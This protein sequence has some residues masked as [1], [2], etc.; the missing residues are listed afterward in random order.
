MTTS[1][2]V[3]SVF[4]DPP[5]RRIREIRAAS[6]AKRWEGGYGTLGQY[7]LE[8]VHPL[9]GRRFLT[10]GRVD[11]M[12]RLQTIVLLLSGVVLA[13][14]AAGAADFETPANQNVTHALPAELDRG[15]RDAVPAPVGAASYM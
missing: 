7:R 9:M 10:R 5:S 3:T 14:V 13:A 1:T 2:A 15:P 8:E 6:C 11:D 12:P 4:I